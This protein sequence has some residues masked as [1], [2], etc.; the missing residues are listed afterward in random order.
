[1]KTKAKTN[2]VKKALIRQYHA[3]LTAA[4]IDENGKAGILEGFKVESTSDLTEA[5]LRQAI[6]AI[7]N[8]SSDGDMWRKRVIAAIG[9]WLKTIGKEENIEYIKGVACGAAPAKNFNRIT[10]PRLRSLYYEFKRDAGTSANVKAF[11]D[12]TID[13]LKKCN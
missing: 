5:Q 13:Y 12:E 8:I 11:K 6:D 2:P 3:V 9:A 4:G 1:M 7:V 10:V